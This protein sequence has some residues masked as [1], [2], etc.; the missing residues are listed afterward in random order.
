MP[1]LVQKQESFS[2]MSMTR[3]AY[4]VLLPERDGHI[5]P[6]VPFPKTFRAFAPG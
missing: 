1:F 6:S 5:F 4:L 2:G 3:R